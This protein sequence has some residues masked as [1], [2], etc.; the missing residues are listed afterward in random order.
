MRKINWKV[1]K[2]WAEAEVGNIS[3]VCY[4]RRNKKKKIYEW[5]ARV[6]IHGICDDGW[7]DG[8]MRRSLKKAQEDS[9]RITREVLCNYKEAVDAEIKRWE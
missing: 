7:K 3:L 4:K 2:Y 5:F 1:E 6:S 8:P 9:I